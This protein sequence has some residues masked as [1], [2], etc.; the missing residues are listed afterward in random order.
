V[1]ECPILHTDRLVL[2]P[3]TLADA[4]DVHR[5]AGERDIASTTLTIPHP[6]E[7]GMAEQW[8]A[9]HQALY[10]KGELLNFAIIHGSDPVL[11]GAIGLHINQQHARAE[12]GHWVGKPFWNRGYGAEAAAAVV[13]HGFGVLGLNRI[14][15]SY[16]RRNPASGRVMQ[17][18]GMTYEGCSRQHVQRWGVFEDLEC[19]GI[20]K[21]EYDLK[22][23]GQSEHS[24]S[25]PSPKIA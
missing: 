16:F 20:L 1:N 21:S 12:L 8:I 24:A 18:I 7:A 11:M 13:G 22:Q 17:K 2:R 5:L 9:T 15:A 19:Y 10:E 14:F 3:F 4:P 25:R 23:A 6:Y